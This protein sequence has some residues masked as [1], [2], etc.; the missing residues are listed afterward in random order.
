MAHEVIDDIQLQA[1][2]GGRFLPRLRGWWPAIGF[3]AA[4][5]ALKPVADKLADV[6]Q[7]RVP[8]ASR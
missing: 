3:T 6:A 4:A 1:V 2:T 7:L 8:S 5:L